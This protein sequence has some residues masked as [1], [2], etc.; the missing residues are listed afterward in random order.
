MT[1][2]DY[3]KEF[4]QLL[5][6]LNVDEVNDVL[7]YYQEYILDADLADYSAVAAKLVPQTVG[8]QTLPIIQL[9]NWDRY[10]NTAA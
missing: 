5:V 2:A 3:L 9:P 10:R 7:E 1:T 8:A 4:E 6:G